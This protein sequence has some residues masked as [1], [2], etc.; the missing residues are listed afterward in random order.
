MDT[1]PATTASFDLGETFAILDRTPSVLDALLRG[2]SPAWHAI[3]EGPDT[4][5]AHLVVAHLIHADESVWPARARIL[6]EHGEA[7][8]FDPVDQGGHFP[9]AAGKTVEELL[10]RFAD[11]R[12]ANLELLRGWELTEAHLSTR[13]L[14][15]SFGTVTLRQLLATWAVHDLNHIGQISRVMAKRYTDDVGPWRAYLSILKR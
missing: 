4:W 8:A 15:P 2:T 11:V 5:S 1:S 10:D 6:R 7:R 3:D 12:R 13:G 9:L 14:H